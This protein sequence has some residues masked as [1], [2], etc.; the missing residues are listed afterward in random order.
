MRDNLCES[1]FKVTNR[2]WCEHMDNYDTAIPGWRVEPNELEGREDYKVCE[3]PK[4]LWDYDLNGIL[5]F[6]D[7][8]GEEDAE[9]IDRL[10][11]AIFRYKTYEDRNRGKNL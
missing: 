3:C 6:L 7:E 1:C 2:R 10:T 9:I 8:Q 4:Y 5:K 11:S